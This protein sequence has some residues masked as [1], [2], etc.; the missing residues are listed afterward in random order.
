MEKHHGIVQMLQWTHAITTTVQYKESRNVKFNSKILI[1][2]I[3]DEKKI[4]N[5]KKREENSGKRTKLGKKEQGEN[6]LPTNIVDGE[7]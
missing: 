6:E 5:V 2:G 3:V 7:T 4:R 1:R